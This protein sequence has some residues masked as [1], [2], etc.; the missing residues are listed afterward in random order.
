MLFVR[1]PLTLFFIAQGVINYDHHFFGWNMQIK[2]ISQSDE[3]KMPEFIANW[4]V[5]ILIWRRQ[6]EIFYNILS[7]LF[8]VGQLSDLWDSEI[9]QR[10]EK[11]LCNWKIGC[12]QRKLVA[13]ICKWMKLIFCEEGCSQDQV[14][15]KK[16]EWDE[17]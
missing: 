7:H 10:W 5:R 1:I 16:V 13:F 3:K 11:K 8:W 17:F 9:L 12:C 15:P 4:H 2:K 6:T 14:A